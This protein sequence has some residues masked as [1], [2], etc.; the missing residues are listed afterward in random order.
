M[1]ITP[2]VLLLYFICRAMS[3]NEVLHKEAT[4]R[5]PG[6][7][8]YLPNLMVKITSIYDVT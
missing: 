7:N 1:S 8:L 2:T 4:P 5:A 3:N 6:V